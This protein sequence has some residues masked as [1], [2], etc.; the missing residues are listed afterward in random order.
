[1]KCKPCRITVAVL[2]ILI[3]TIGYRF[4]IQGRV[5]TGTDGRTVILLAPGERDLVLSEMRQFLESV[6]QITAG[7]INNDLQVV[8]QSARFS[9]SRARQSVPGSLMGKLPLGFKQLGFD[10]HAKFDELALDAEQLGDR[11]HVLSQLNVV[12]ENCVAC[13]AAYRLDS[14]L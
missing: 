6:Q 9:G 14:E 4:I 2:V 12:L 8:A 3:A 7:A 1:M 5:K 11:D 13:H 10:T